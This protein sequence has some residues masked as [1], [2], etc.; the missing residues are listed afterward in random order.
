MSLLTPVPSAPRASHL[1]PCSLHALSK[2][3]ANDSGQEGPSHK[4]RQG[5]QM[6]DVKDTRDLLGVN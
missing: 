3:Q 4:I 2:P 1:A 6:D 5:P